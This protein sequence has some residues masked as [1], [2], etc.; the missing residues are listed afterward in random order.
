MKKEVDEQQKDIWVSFDLPSRY[1]DLISKQLLNISED[2]RKKDN[3][4]FYY[5]SCFY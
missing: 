3:N 1:K 5:E 2:K 4:P